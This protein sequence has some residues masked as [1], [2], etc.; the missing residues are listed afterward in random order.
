MYCLGIMGTVIS[1]YNKRLILL[2]V[3]QLSGGHCITI[4]CTVQ[5]LHLQIQQC[6]NE[7]CKRLKDYKTVLYLDTTD[8]L[9]RELVTFGSAPS[10]TK[11]PDFRLEIF[12]Q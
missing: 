11:V 7:I 2:S 3:I 6:K 8:D 12:V 1:D 9:V 5:R 4:C 10:Q